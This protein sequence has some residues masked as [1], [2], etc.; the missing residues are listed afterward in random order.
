M[1]YKENGFVSAYSIH[2]CQYHKKGNVCISVFHLWLK[3]KEKKRNGH[4]NTQTLNS[5][6]HF[7]KSLVKN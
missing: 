7:F 5:H 4:K 2:E 1:L 3:K 6:F